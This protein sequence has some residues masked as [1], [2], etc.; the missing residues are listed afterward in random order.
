MIVY[1]VTVK[2]DVELH[3]E[4]LEWMKNV[5]IPDVVRTGCFTG[6]RMLKVLTHDEPDGIT[7]SIQ[8][9]CNSMDDY[10]K[11]EHDF[12]PRLRGLHNEKYKDRFVAFRTLLEEV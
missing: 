4:W 1:N 5:H 7:Y 11:Y 12:A 3:D 8:Y 6:S 9:S 2:I 10:L